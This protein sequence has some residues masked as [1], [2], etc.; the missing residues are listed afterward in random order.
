MSLAIETITVGGIED[1]RLEMS[2]VQA[3][4][5][6]NIGTDWQ[7]LRLGIRIAV[8]D[9]GAS[10]LGPPRLYYGALSNPAAG[11][12][13]G[14]LT[15]TCSHFVGFATGSFASH[16]ARTAGPPPYYNISNG[17]AGIQTPA[18]KKVGNTI[19]PVVATAINSYIPTTGSL[20]RGISM[21]Q[22]AKGSPNFTIIMVGQTTAT[23]PPDCTKNFLIDAMGQPTMSNAA[24]RL[25]TLT[26]TT[27][28]AST[29]LVLAVSEATDGFLDS[30]CIAWNVASPLIYISDFFWAKMA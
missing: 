4:R 23:P 16:W 30:I 17:S 10:L 8:V 27:Y 19:T 7:T 20:S 9:T 13:N 18:V 29:G 25:S 15:A 24:T 26:G 6:I 22:I 5:Y 1:R 3:A 12:T 21:M 2:N 14:P 28:S 11:M